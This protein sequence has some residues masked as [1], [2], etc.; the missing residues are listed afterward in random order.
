VR[1]HRLWI[2][3]FG[4]FAGEEEVDFDS[5]ADGGLFLLHGPTGLATSVLDAVCFALYGSVPGTRAGAGRLRSDH[6]PAAVGAAV[7][8]EFSVG[9]RRFE[10]TRSPAWERAKKRGSGTT[11]EQAR[12]L[13]RERVGQDWQPRTQR[14]D[15]AADLLGSVLGLAA[16]QFTKLV[17]LPQGEF[18]AFLRADAEA[19]RQLLDRLFRP[20]GST[21][22]REWLRDHQPG[23]AARSRARSRPPGS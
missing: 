3:A 6:A 8:C 4:P 1:L 19:R 10:V 9:S 23:A 22:S 11:T 2:R 13:V 18:A 17:L 15:E 7:R 20:T 5:L 12:V 14:I 16:D 21:P